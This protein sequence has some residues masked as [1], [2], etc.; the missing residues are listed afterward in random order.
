MAK[1]ARI[2]KR[3]PTQNLKVVNNPAWQE[4]SKPSRLGVLK[5]YKLYI[6]GKFPRSDS[7]QSYV[8]KSPGGA[9]LAN[10]CLG[11][12]KDI[13]NAVVAAR[14][15]FPIWSGRSAYNRGQILY[16]MAEMLEGRSKQF[17][18]ELQSQGISARN[19]KQEVELSIDRLV[20]YAGWS[21]KYHQIFSAVNPVNSSHFNF[22][23]PEPT[24]V[25]ALVAPEKPSLLGLLSTMAPI[26]VGG[27]TMVGLCS[28]SMPLSSV[29]FAEVINS[30]DLPAGVVN[31][32]TGERP[33]LLP[34]LAKHMDVNA[35]VYC[36]AESDELKQLQIDAAENLKRVVVKAARGWEDIDAQGPYQIMDVQE[37]K[38]TWHPIGG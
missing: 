31:L 13:R 23:V 37:I 34:H 26:I 24:G 19:A 17:A 16:R 29:S 2:D 20:Y 12:R 11:S 38:T 32:L 27:N 30:S 6:D 22:S 36:G 21:D 14:R 15:A 4:H 1:A 5:T 9:Q 8:L 25:V 3:K 33:E 28:Y 10:I 7:E 35:I 18:D